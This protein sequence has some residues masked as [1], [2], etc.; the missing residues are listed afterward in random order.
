MSK[1]LVPLPIF[2]PLMRTID[3]FGFCAIT[4]SKAVANIHAIFARMAVG[5]SGVAQ[6][7]HLVAAVGDVL[8]VGKILDPDVQVE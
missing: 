5:E 8:F 3:Q 6:L 2:D 7:Q 1:R 4:R